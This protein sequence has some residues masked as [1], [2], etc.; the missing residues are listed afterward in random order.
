MKM[1]VRA[2]DKCGKRVK[3]NCDTRSKVVGDGKV[4]RMCAVC[5]TAYKKWLDENNEVVDDAKTD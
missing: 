3:T 1:A 5:L 2:C 4:C